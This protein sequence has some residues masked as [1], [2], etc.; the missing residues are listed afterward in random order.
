MAN[1]YLDIETYGK[2]GESPYNYEIITIQY[3]KILQQTGKPIKG[4]SLT[5]LKSWETSEEEIIK[6]FLKQL[7][8]EETWHFIP[9]GCRLRYE[10]LVISKRAKKYG[11]N[12]N[13]EDFLI[14]PHVD[15]HPILLIL[16]KGSFKGA[17]LDVFTKKEKSGID[18]LDLYEKKKYAEIIKYIELET[19]E[20]LKLYQWFLRTFPN[21]YEADYEV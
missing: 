21:I 10:F 16:N 14:H 3:Q 15:I 4:E 18:I 11:L 9:V 1:H 20:F 7:K 5:V 19:E 17:R 8:I 13:L 2:K 12:L 6:T